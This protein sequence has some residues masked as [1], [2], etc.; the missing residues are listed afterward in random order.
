MSRFEGLKYDEIAERLQ[1]SPRTV[2][3]QIGKALRLLR[4]A[5]AEWLPVLVAWLGA[6]F[7]L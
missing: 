5:L 7:F 1:L 6:E 2:E 4:D 3:V